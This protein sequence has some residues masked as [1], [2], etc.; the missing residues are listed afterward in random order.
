[1]TAYRLRTF[2]PE[3]DPARA[4]ALEVDRKSVV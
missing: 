2:A 1:M 4:R 3:I